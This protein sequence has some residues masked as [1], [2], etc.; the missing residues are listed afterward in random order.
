MAKKVEEAVA[1]IFESLDQPDDVYDAVDSILEA[2]GGEAMKR[3]ISLVAATS[4]YNP[5]GDDKPP[6]TYAY[7]SPMECLGLTHWLAES[8]TSGVA[9]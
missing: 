1:A 3:G 8:V 2:L 5:L 4:V 7:G 6:I 9:T